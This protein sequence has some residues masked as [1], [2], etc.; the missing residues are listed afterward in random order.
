MRDMRVW[1]QL[2][3]KRRVAQ[4][5]R[6]VQ[7]LL[8]S[9]ERDAVMLFVVIRQICSRQSA[10]TMDIRVGIDGTAVRCA[11]SGRTCLCANTNLAIDWR[12]RLS[13]ALSMK[14]GMPLGPRGYNLL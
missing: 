11:H 10:S 8:S 3:V 14:D 9:T 4:L 13:R 5:V 2:L 7:Y 1:L 12:L 6:H